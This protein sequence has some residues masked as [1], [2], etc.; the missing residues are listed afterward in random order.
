MSKPIRSMLLLGAA[1]H[2]SI[3]PLAATVPVVLAQANLPAPYV[4]RAFDAVVL[5]ID[6][7]VRSAFALNAADSGVLVLAVAHDGV[8]AQN[9]VEPGEIIHQVKGKDIATPIELDEVVYF[10]LTQ[11][12]SDF[13]VDYYRAGVL[14]SSDVI[15]TLELYEA[16]L[17][18]AAVSNWTSWSYEGFSYE[19]YTVEYSEEI[20]ETYEESETTIEETVTSEEFSSELEEDSQEDEASDESEEAASD[21][22]DADDGAADDGD[23]ADDGGEDDGA[24]DGDGGEEE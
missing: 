8:A 11:Q 13:S 3:L 19:E 5:P 4:S 6:E 22:A 17:D 2:L 16:A 15:I 18:V 10:W 7:S 20:V 1:A 14:S 23:E 12:V 9:G 24:D 21:D